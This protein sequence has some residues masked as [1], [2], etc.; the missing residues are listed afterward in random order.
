MAFSLHQIVSE[1]TADN[2]LTETYGRVLNHQAIRYADALGYEGI[3]FVDCEPHHLIDRNGDRYLDFVA[4][5]AVHH[6]GRRHPVIED[7]LSQAASAPY[8]NL[9]QIGVPT[10]STILAARLVEFAGGDFK[11]VFF[12]NSG[13]ETTDYAIKMAI[14]ATKRDK[15]LYFNGDYHGLTLCALSVNGV[16]KQQKLFH[17]DGQNIQVP[18]NDID[19]LKSAFAQH[20]NEIAGMIIEPVQARFGQVATEEFMAE[21]RALCDRNGTLLILDEIKSGFGR[22]GRNFFHDWVS[23]APDI[24]MLAKG[25]S[26]GAVSS[27]ALLFGE[28]LYK[29]VFKDVERL[30]VFSST[31]RE[32]NFAMA[33]GLAVLHLM[34]TENPCENVLLAERCIRERLHGRSLPSGEHI[35]VLGKGLQLSVHV[36]GRG[37][38]AARSLIDTIE[39]DLFYI[40]CARH[41]MREHNIVTMLPNRFGEALAVVPALNISGDHVDQFCEAV[42]ET[43]AH[44]VGKSTIQ[45]MGDVFQ[46]AKKLI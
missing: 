15:M 12:T 42:L 3:E 40:L 1:F 19:T 11:R 4:G 2:D 10:L 44:M 26:G 46:G 5:F 37:K 28:A 45:Y 29:T 31:F 35:E 43:F 41:L 27:G 7:A 32:N 16:T 20:G 23:V 18:F 33:A 38:S 30:A 22:T 25:L 39:G 17:V 13:A 6:W 9:V 14:A 24:L 8:P 34:E 21:A 36:S